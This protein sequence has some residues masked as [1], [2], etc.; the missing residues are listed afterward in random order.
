M[1]LGNQW[2]YLPEENDLIILR[3]FFTKY[4]GDNLVEIFNDA[5]EKNKLRKKI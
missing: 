1:A 3:K 4:Y 2:Q 5:I